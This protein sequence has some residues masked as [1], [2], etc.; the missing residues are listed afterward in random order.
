LRRRGEGADD[1]CGEGGEERRRNFH[2]VFA[3]V[4]F[5]CF[6]GSICL[7]RFDDKPY[8]QNRA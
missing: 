7:R 5:Y 6:T 1:G 3:P 2:D 8:R 4:E